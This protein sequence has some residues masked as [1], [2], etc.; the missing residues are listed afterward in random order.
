MVIPSGRVRRNLVGSRGLA[1]SP[2]P[3]A[4][5]LAAVALASA[6]AE[7]WSPQQRPAG[8]RPRDGEGRPRPGSAAGVTVL[9]R[10]R[11]D[12]TRKFQEGQP[13]ERVRAKVIRARR[14]E[15]I[16]VDASVRLRCPNIQRVEG[17]PLPKNTGNRFFGSLD[18]LEVDTV[19][20]HHVEAALIEADEIVAVTVRSGRGGLSR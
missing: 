19:R 9:E 11:R 12:L 20:A 3:I 2:L 17:A 7:G 15:A 14:I 6:C 5:F 16:T 8:G 13:W 10:V 4:C 1:A 18:L